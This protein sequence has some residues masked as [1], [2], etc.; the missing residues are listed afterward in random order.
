MKLI[1]LNK[2]NSFIFRRL[3]Y[4]FGNKIELGYLATNPLRNLYRFVKCK[5]KFKKSVLFTYRCRHFRSRPRQQAAI[6]RQAAQ[7]GGQRAGVQLVHELV[8]RHQLLWHMLG[9][10]AAAAAA[11]VRVRVVRPIDRAASALQIVHRR[12]RVVRHVTRYMRL[13]LR[14]RTALTRS[15]L[16]HGGRRLGGCA[17]RQRRIEVQLPAGAGLAT[18][19]VAGARVRFRRSSDV[20]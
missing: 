18:G 6:Q 9:R 16:T 2:L 5:T 12:I 19:N 10:C 14:G 1:K 4:I 13:R 17:R 20:R 15:R 7:L 8:V 11:A 3:I